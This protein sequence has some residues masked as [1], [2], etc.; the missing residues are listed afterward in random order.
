[1]GSGKGEWTGLTSLG[2]EEVVGSYECGNELSG[3]TKFGEFL[4]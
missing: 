2:I 1:L 3:P 4:D